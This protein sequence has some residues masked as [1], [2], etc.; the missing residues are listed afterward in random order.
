MKTA[1]NYFDKTASDW[2][3]DWLSE[4]EQSKMVKTF[5]E[6]FSGADNFHPRILDA[7]CGAGYDC[8]L[9]S[10][11]GA[12]IVGIDFSEKLIEIAKN[13]VHNCTFYQKSLEEDLQILGKFDGIFCS[14]VLNYVDI[15]KLKIVFDN[16]A[17]ITKK[18]GLLFLS[19][20]DGNG[21]NEQKSYSYIDGEEYDLNFYS[22]SSEQ[23]C[24]LAKPYFKL[25]DTFKF[26]NFSYG[27]KNYVFMKI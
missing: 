7:G 8:K 18:S 26:D 9:F 22:L 6:L 3:D 5:Y 14:S 16:F 20:H 1:L 21:K 15:T 12:N 4:K 17:L 13:N 24:S 25:V 2:S 10:D 19:V 11:Y 27:Y 23:L